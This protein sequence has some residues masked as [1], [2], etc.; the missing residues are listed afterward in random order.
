MAAVA[1]AAG[2]S[3]NTV[4]LVL[5]HSPQ[6]PAQTQKRIQRIIKKL[7]YQKNPVVAHLMVQLRQS[8]SPRYQASIALLN[9][10]RD[11]HAFTRHPTIPDYIEGCKKRATQLGYTL[12]P[13]W[14]HDPEID[15]IKMGRILQARNIQGAILVG[16]MDENKLPERYAS[17]WKR[18]ACVVTGVRTENP[19][20]SFCCTDHHSIALGAFQQALRLGYQR[21]AL[22]LDAKIDA[23][24]EGRF[25][26]GIL[27][28]QRALPKK[29]QIPGFYDVPTA[30]Q[31]PA[32]FH[33]WLRHWKPDV[34]FTLYDTV[35]TW[36]KMA[37]MRIPH[38]IGVI[39]LEVR[40]QH[41]GQAGMRQNN[42]L[43]GAAAVDMVVQLIHSGVNDLPRIPTA[44]MVEGSWV[45]GKTIRVRS[46]TY[47][48][49]QK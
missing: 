4:S 40:R 12:D 46:T 3:K 30:R 5:R 26:S 28:G 23:L 2:V 44:T 45:H 31:N 11:P 9:A 34:I 48:L 14:L 1:R 19:T 20:L 17:L 37:G 49:K 15:G 6:I 22:V 25:T 36:I 18:I 43:V 13:F 42:D 16:L 27:I 29:N 41:K 39:Q 38:D 7:G 21:P 33:R 35:H 8:R 10:H 47:C 24:V 32:I